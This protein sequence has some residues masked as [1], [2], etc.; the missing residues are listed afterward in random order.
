MI[1][2]SVHICAYIF[3]TWSSNS[4][5]LVKE[6]SRSIRY[7]TCWPE[8]M[9]HSDKPLLKET[10]R[11]LQLLLRFEPHLQR[12]ESTTLTTAP[13]PLTSCTI[14]Y[15]RFRLFIHCFTSVCTVYTMIRR[16]WWLNQTIVSCWHI[17]Q[18]TEIL[19]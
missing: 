15:C 7:F 4:K 13:I 14:I 2:L 16:C 19:A 9:K 6:N 17:V 18:V 1:A 10:M 11:K 3:L 5:L 12:W 8:H